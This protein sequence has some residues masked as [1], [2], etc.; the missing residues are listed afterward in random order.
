V[1]RFAVCTAVALAGCPQ[2]ITTIGGLDGTTGSTNRDGSTP[3]NGDGGSFADALPSDAPIADSGQQQL[4]AG[5]ADAGFADASRPDA[6]GSLAPL[7]WGEAMVTPNLGAVNAVWGRSASD[8]YIGTSR[9]TVFRWDGTTWTE[10]FQAPSN[11]AIEGIW[12]TASKLFV[13]SE[14]ALN[15]IAGS[16]TQRI[17]VPRV[18][19]INGIWGRA[20]DDVYLTVEEQNGTSLL[21]YDGASLSEAYRP[22]AGPLQTVWSDDQGR[23]WIGGN[24][25]QLY[26]QDRGVIAPEQVEFPMQWDR[27]DLAHFNFTTVRGFGDQLFAAGS[28]FLIFR[29]HTDGVWRLDHSPFLTNEITGMAGFAGSEIYASGRSPSS[30]PLL[31]WYAGAWSSA[32]LDQQYHLF[33][34]WAAGPDDYF[35]VGMRRNTVNGVVLRGFR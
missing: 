35:A 26:I 18:R 12:G 22:A 6:G 31:R 29:R 3:T 4:D 13:A 27:N 11:R 16:D 2:P 28:R 8:V 1:R 14:V 19:S 20:D 21:R 5:S 33:D 23:M 30:G 25:G 7:R 34:I 32:N 9:G 17:N 15:I 24:G 10:H